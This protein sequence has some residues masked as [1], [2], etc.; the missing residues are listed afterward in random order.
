MFY[1]SLFFMKKCPMCAEE[2]QDEAIKCKHCKSELVLKKEEFA[3]KKSFLKSWKFWII[4]LSTL[5]LITILSWWNNPNPT[6]N[7]VYTPQISEKDSY[8]ANNITIIEND[9]KNWLKKQYKEAWSIKL[10]PYSI[11]EWEIKIRWTIA[12]IKKWTTR[13]AQQT[14][15]SY[16]W[17]DIKKIYSAYEYEIFE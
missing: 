13:S 11:Y 5:L 2:I 7:L 1:Y 12:G 10:S 4:I 15:C 14:L 3:K 17:D 8:I 9:C 6:Y 16:K